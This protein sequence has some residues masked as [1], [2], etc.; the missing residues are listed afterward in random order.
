MSRL[1]VVLAEDNYEDLELH[2][3][4]LRL[5]EA[6]FRVLVVAPEAKVYQSKF[7]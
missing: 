1:A 6:G 3:P 4:R 5:M 7:G 2:Y